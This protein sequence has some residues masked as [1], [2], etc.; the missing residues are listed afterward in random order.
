[1]PEYFYT[2]KSFKGEVKSGIL[3]AK[4]Q[5]E[6]ARILHQ[7]GYFLISAGLEEKEIKKRKF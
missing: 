5:S 7:E 6:L 1:M 2:A 4:N 3:S